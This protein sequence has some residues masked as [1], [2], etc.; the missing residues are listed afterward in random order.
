MATVAVVTGVAVAGATVGDGGTDVG[1]GTVCVAVGTAVAALDGVVG[2]GVGV[3]AANVAVG[4]VPSTAAAATTPRIQRRIKWVES[5]PL[6][7][8][9]TLL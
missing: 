3:D 2:V 9:S 4:T 6:V 7:R 1:L 8:R 5:E